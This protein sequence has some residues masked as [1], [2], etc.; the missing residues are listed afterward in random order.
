MCCS[1]CYLSFPHL[2]LLHPDKT[3]LPWLARPLCYCSCVTNTKLETGSR[4][5]RVL[6][7]TILNNFSINPT[8]LK[9]DLTF[10]K[11]FNLAVTGLQKKSVFKQEAGE[12]GA[13]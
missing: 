5:L 13:R 3:S 7:R 2:Y 6:K 1:V 10:V 4:C 11:A 9:Y 12:V 8:S